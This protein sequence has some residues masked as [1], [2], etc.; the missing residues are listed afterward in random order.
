M[1][2]L[3]SMEDIK[4]I[5]PEG[6]A[7]KPS[8][9]KDYA[10]Y[11][12][13]QAKKSSDL[14]DRI[15]QDSYSKGVKRM[16]GAR[17]KEGA[18]KNAIIR[19]Q[20]MKEGSKQSGSKIENKKLSAEDL[21]LQQNITKLIYHWKDNLKKKTGDRVIDEKRDKEWL[22]FKKDPYAG[23]IA[24]TSNALNKRLADKARLGDDPNKKALDE[25]NG[26]I[27]S[28]RDNLS[29]I[30]LAKEKKLPL[31]LDQSF[32]IKDI[33]DLDKIHEQSIITIT[34][35]GGE[36]HYK[37]EKM[38]AGN[39]YFKDIYNKDKGARPLVLKWNKVKEFLS[40][41]NVDYRILEVNDGK[42]NKKTN[43]RE[44][45]KV[46][47]NTLKEVTKEKDD[48]K[49]KLEREE[50]VYSIMK[51]FIE[52]SEEYDKRK[53]D[54]DRKIKDL[55]ESL[56]KAL[57][58]EK[59]EKD[60][61][62]KTSPTVE[63]KNDAADGKENVFM[64]EMKKIKSA[65]LENVNKISEIREEIAKENELKTNTNRWSFGRFKQN[66]KIKKLESAI[67]GLETSNHVLTERFE[68]SGKRQFPFAY[69]LARNIKNPYIRSHYTNKGLDAM[70][71][72]NR[73]YIS[74]YEINPID[75][76]I[77]I[78]DPVTKSENPYFRPSE[79]KGWIVK[80]NLYGF[81]IKLLNPNEVADYK[82]DYDPK[83]ERARYTV[84]D[85]DGK[86]LVENAD[87]GNSL[88]V[89]EESTEK[90]KKLAEED[91]KKMKR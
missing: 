69:Y 89:Y 40:N 11:K 86:I 44:N 62:D 79:K 31:N 87:N 6:V 50:L 71:K 66:N 90:Y 67:R 46:V 88:K 77:D 36:K 48:E 80:F 20:E 2:K 21:R 54:R 28:H 34:S 27:K 33:S 64:N 41:P 10:A 18:Y 32:Y 49:S 85:H 55:E 15:F 37:I 45:E 91:F 35:G 9:Y 81:S 70:G 52:Q 76:N 43:N 58:K 60:A 24:H 13:D 3:D 82:G 4:K 23:V 61:K 19:E 39:V 17:K 83:N 14:I 57:A 12:K 38:Q 59:A 63:N 53:K 56:N 1:A 8:E 51:P 73:P 16:R 42:E 5:I 47:K 68:E 78:V 72:I 84:F 22:E 29:Q 74:M 30:E 25:L 65:Y 75:K 26:V 7:E